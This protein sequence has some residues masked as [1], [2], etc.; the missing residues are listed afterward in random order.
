[1]RNY[2]KTGKFKNLHADKMLNFQGFGE[3]CKSGGKIDTIVDNIVASGKVLGPS[4]KC[5]YKEILV[6]NKPNDKFDASGLCLGNLM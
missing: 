1:M 6:D 3:Y 4:A 2:I 5:H